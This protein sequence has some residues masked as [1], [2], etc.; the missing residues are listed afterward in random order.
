MLSWEKMSHI[1]KAGAIYWDAYKDAYGFRPRNIDTTEWSLTD[2]HNEIIRL[3][4]I[5]MDNEIRRTHEEAKSED[6]VE[7]TIIN[8]LEAGA[9][10]REMCIRWLLEA[11]DCGTDRNLL[12]FTLGTR[13]GYFD[14]PRD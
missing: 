7:R 11:H 3:E 1:E 9:Q 5:I 2:F 14:A 4:E 12:C 10:D 6:S 13:Y 8:L